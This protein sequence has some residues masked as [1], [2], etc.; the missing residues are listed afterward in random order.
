MIVT[1]GNATP[2]SSEMCY[3][4]R[5]QYTLLSVCVCVCVCVHKLGVFEVMGMGVVEKVV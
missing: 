5:H 4:A 3:I 1:S 2:V